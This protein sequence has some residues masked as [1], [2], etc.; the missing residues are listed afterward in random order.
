[1][2]V[3]QQV[4]LWAVNARQWTAVLR[5]ARSIQ[6]A[7]ALGLRWS[8]W[9]EVL[10]QALT[11]ARAAGDRA[12]TAWALHELGTRSL[13]L[14]ERD[15]ARKALNSAW[16]QR[17]EANQAAAALLTRHNLDLLLQPPAQAR[18]ARPAAPRAKRNWKSF[19]AMGAGILLL[20]ALAVTVVVVAANVLGGDST[21]TPEPESARPTR[22]VLP[23]PIRT[24][25]GQHPGNGPRINST[26]PTQPKPEPTPSETPQTNI[27]ILEYRLGA[28]LWRPNPCL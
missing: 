18:Q 13:C 24:P 23:G 10:R 15:V 1:M 20:A 12:S 7:L 11:A 21:P 5:L 25:G 6:P 22:E 14:G 4:M 27:G 26:T 2:E 8:A 9:A 3:L 28:S 19:L 16:K 17:Q